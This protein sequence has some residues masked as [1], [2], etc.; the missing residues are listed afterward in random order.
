MKSEEDGE[1]KGVPADAEVETETT[2]QQ[3]DN[4]SALTINRQGEMFTYCLIRIFS[5]Q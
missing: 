2:T 3:Q 1:A 4:D 5:V